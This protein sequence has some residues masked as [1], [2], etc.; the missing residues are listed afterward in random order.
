MQD[1]NL[2]RKY[3]AAAVTVDL[4][5]LPNKN[6]LIQQAK[7]IMTRLFCGEDDSLSNSSHSEEESAET[8]EEKSLILYKKLEKVIHSKSKVQ[9]YS[10]SK[11]SSLS[12]IVKQELFL[13]DSIENLSSNIIKLGKALKINP[14]TS[15]EAEREFSAAGFFITKLRTKLRDKSTDY[16]FS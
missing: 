4:S 10:T 6:S 3:D 2:G 11:S 7:I 5:R 8:L 14:S 16:L 15:A 12:K 13:F 1:L 9:R